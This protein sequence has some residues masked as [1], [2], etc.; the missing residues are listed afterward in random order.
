MAVLRADP[1]FGGVW[2]GGRAVRHRPRPFDGDGDTI[3]TVDIGAYE[4]Q[5]TADRI[6]GRVL[7][8]LD[9]DG[10]L[11][12]VVG[13][14]GQTNAVY[15]NAGDGTF[16]ISRTVDAG[17]ADTRG[18]TLGDIDGD[19]D[20]EVLAARKGESAADYEAHVRA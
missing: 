14:D 12:A 9:G 11:D 3:A 16:P 7:E 2:S 5:Q 18:V 20:S 15:V 17:L 4:S 8:D 1:G 13:N 10:D 6:S 19:G